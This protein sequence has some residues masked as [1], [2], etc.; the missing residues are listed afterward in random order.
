MSEFVLKQIKAILE[1]CLRIKT[2][3]TPEG[4]S[5]DLPAIEQ[6]Q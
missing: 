4:K 1:L 5:L 3:N 6:L 2:F